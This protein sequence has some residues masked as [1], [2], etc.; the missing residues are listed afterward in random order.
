MFTAYK[1]NLDSSLSHKEH[2]NDD[3]IGSWVYDYAYGKYTTI[4]VVQD[5]T[6]KFCIYTD[7]GNDFELIE[8]GYL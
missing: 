4:K 5:L 1:I 7:N 8:R 6:N 3:E 2:L